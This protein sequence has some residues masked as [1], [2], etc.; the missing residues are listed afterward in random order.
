[1]HR[2][3][4]PPTR[5]RPAP[6]LFLI[7][8]LA[9]TACGPSTDDQR[10][11]TRPVIVLGID[12]GEWSV[13]ERLWEEGKLPHLKAFAERGVTAP[14]ATNYTASPVIW[15]TIATG[16]R[17]EDHGITDFVI[18]TPEGDVPVSSTL[19]RV[20]ALWNMLTLARHKVGVLGWWATW[21]AE[22][23]QGLVVSDRVLR[24]QLEQ[25]VWPAERLAEI[26]EEIAL[27]D[28]EPNPFDPEGS[29]ARQDHLMARL[30]PQLA[31]EDYDLLLVYLRGVDVAS[32]KT[33]RYFSP[34]EFPDLKATPEEMASEGARI[35]RE[36]EAVD[37]TLGAILAAAEPEANV[38]VISD[39]GFKAAPEET[40]RVFWNFDLLLERLGFLHRQEDDGG[41]LGGVDLTRSSLYT[42]QS[43]DFKQR[44]MI[45]FPQ[46]GREKG[47]WVGPQ[48]RQDVRQRL[49]ET[50]ARV[51]FSNGE[52]A[53]RIRDP[54][55]G[56]ARRGAD[57]MVVMETE[58]ATSRLLFE[59]EGE[60]GE[61]EPDADLLDGVITEMSRISGTHTTHTSGIFLAAGPDVDAAANLEGIKIHDVAPTLLF[62]LGLPVAENFAGRAW[63]ELFT[64][65]FRQSHPLR[66]VPAWKM[67][68]DSTAT[69]SAADDE[70]IQ[71]L[72]SLG[73][74]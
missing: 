13:I 12:G 20:P 3:K 17:P 48:E 11:A 37:R 15:T 21:P 32:H 65:K 44:K 7:L 6:C 25:R 28:A 55:P 22:E 34:E 14:L 42:Y 47:G 68:R 24:P 74:L 50:L 41:V 2:S 29:A 27:A 71:E 45:R 61:D 53:F 5:Q 49:E 30:A 23:V 35:P 51:S 52:P 9:V 18:A 63:T 57:L 4:T 59:S 19:R 26:E 69:P 72:K 66:T 67:D 54:R 39:H 33:W 58:N 36:Y 10:Q 43:P 60:E 70:L 40:V 62:A 73:Y 56:E 64:P 38:F 1:M 16:R 8:A 31:A 46:A